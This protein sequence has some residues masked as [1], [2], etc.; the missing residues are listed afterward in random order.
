MTVVVKYSSRYPYLPEAV[1]DNFHDLGRI[2]GV[3]AS[4]VSH[5]VH[6]GSEQYKVVDITEWWPTNDGCLWTYDENGRVIIKE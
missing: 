4:A 1:G 2:L 6:R 3:T 5:A